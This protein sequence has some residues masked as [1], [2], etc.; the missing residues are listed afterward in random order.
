MISNLARKNQDRT[1]PGFFGV[2]VESDSLFHAP[3]LLGSAPGRTR[4][5]PSRHSGL[6][7]MPTDWRRQ[8]RPTVEPGIWSVWLSDMRLGSFNEI[9]HR[10][11][12]GEQM[13]R[14][15]D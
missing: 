5:S 14:R 8:K 2:P 3:I 13:T 9:S 11:I 4:S 1:E 6:P 10:M 7:L 15:S 12:W